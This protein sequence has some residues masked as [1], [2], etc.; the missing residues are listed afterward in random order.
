MHAWDVRYMFISLVICMC[1]HMLLCSYQT[2]KC[3][4]SGQTWHMHAWGQMHLW[5]C[6]CP[7]IHVWT[8]LYMHCIAPTLNCQVWIHASMCVT[9]DCTIA[10]FHVVVL[11]LIVSVLCQFLC[12]WQIGLNLSLASHTL[13][14]GFITE[15]MFSSDD[16][17]AVDQLCTCV[18]SACVRSAWSAPW[19][20]QWHTH[21]FRW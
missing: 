11:M 15:L 5:S 3:V 10:H 8:Y 21:R 19:W 18:G 6:K 7:C 13:V 12:W 2:C 1:A 16:G 9:I 20:S 14:F 17:L 4:E